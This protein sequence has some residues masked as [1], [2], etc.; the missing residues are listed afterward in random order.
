MANKFKYMRSLKLSYE[1]QG[2]IFF[3]C[4]RFK[5]L[6][7]D[8]Q[9]RIKEICEACADGD[10]YKRRAIMAFM[11]TTATWQECCMRY[12]ISDSTMARLR[13]KFYELWEVL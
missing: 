8:E 6:C 5:R 3:T 4:L 7:E 9:E 1:R 10:S 11:T 2:E 13:K 12:H